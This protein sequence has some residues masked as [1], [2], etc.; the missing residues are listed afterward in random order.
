MSG[1]AKSTNAPAGGK[2]ENKNLNNVMKPPPRPLIGSSNRGAFHVMAGDMKR[3]GKSVGSAAAP[4]AAPV[5][6]NTPSLRRENGGKD[7]NVNLIATAGS[8]VWGGPSDAPKQD[9]YQAVSGAPPP[10][11]TSPAATMPKTAPWAKSDDS[12]SGGAPVVSMKKNWADVDSDDENEVR[13]SRSLTNA[14]KGGSG[15]MDHRGDASIL[16]SIR[17]RASNFADYNGLEGRYGRPDD[18]SDGQQHTTNAAASQ[19]RYGLGAGPPPPTGNNNNMGRGN[20]GFF[21]SQDPR[22]DRDRDRGGYQPMNHQGTK[23][24]N[25]LASIITQHVITEQNTP[26]IKTLDSSLPQHKTSP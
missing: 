6:M 7:V 25:P 16:D 24:N 21:S 23:Q 1:V 5:P 17:H 12:S 11:P 14:N 13:A 3:V 10:P 15:G 26:R 19:Q 4:V 20:M 22:G 2:F 18:S 9:G 8:V